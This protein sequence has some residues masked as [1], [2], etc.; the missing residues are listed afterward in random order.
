MNNFLKYVFSIDTKSSNRIIIY[1]FGIRIRFL[2]SGI[3]EKYEKCTCPVSDIPKAT[4][5]LRK[6]QLA[7]LKMMLIF[8]KLCKEN[9]FEYWLDFGNLLGAV[10]H[11][12]F[13]PW[14][15]DVDLGMC[16]DDYEK[17]IE[18]YKKGIPE[19][20]DLYLEFDNN[21]K[22][23]CFVKIKHKKL[24][25][26]ALDIFPY[27]FYYKKTSEEENLEIT[28]KIRKIQKK[29]IH[30]LLQPIFIHYPEGMRKRFFHLRDNDILQG[31]KP[32][33]NDK[34]SLFYGFDYPHPYNNYFFDYD[35]IFPLKTI[36]YENYDFFCPNQ[37]DLFLRQIF[38]DYMI[39]PDDCYPR[40]TNTEGFDESSLNE[41]I[42]DMN[43]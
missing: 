26:V 37:Y 18:K 30:K 19:C 16:R 5:I 14:D 32:D 9:G 17:F 4:G 36:K 43:A 6:I 35:K 41:F 13:I 1:V 38:G 27:D 11:G 28:K 12:G 40:H 29:F 21:G 23:K 33:K 31:H 10:R 25:N 2:K 7:N 20:S 24:I 3:K 22:D 8:D 42:G 34:P 39:L 15:D